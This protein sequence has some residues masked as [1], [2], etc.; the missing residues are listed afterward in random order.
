MSIGDGNPYS[1]TGD[2]G[3]GVGYGPHYYYTPHRFIVLHPSMLD[4]L[5]C[6]VD[7]VL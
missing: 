7:A 3:S 4:R 5:D 6:G 2:L 1:S